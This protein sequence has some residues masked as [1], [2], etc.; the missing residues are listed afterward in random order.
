MVIALPIPR[1]LNVFTASCCHYSQQLD[2][3]QGGYDDQLVPHDGRDDDSDQSHLEQHQIPLNHSQ[4]NPSRETML[5]SHLNQARTCLPNRDQPPPTAQT[6]S[7]PLTF[8]IIPSNRWPLG[9]ASLA[10][11]CSKYQRAASARSIHN[12]SQM[13][14]FAF[15]LLVANSL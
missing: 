14:M 12:A 4:G 3:G 15:C 13:Q 5:T 9:H 7:L 11:L 8:D 2:D 6:P 1:A 10:P